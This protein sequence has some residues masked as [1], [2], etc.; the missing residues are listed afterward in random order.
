MVGVR[1][2]PAV[3]EETMKV[4]AEQ[5]FDG[6]ACDLGYTTRE[7]KKGAIY[8]LPEKLAETFCALATR[9]IAGIVPDFPVLSSRIRENRDFSTAPRYSALCLPTK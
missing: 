8:D 9:K 7:Y 6:A 5:N 1:S 3:L 2:A 4:Q